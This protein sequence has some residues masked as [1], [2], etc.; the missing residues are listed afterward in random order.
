MAYIDSGN[1]DTTHHDVNIIGGDV[2]DAYRALCK[3]DLSS[4][5]TGAVVKTATLKNTLSSVDSTLDTELTLFRITQAWTDTAVTWNNAPEYEPTGIGSLSMSATEPTGLKSTTLSAFHINELHDGSFPDNGFLLL[6]SPEGGTVKTTTT[7]Y[8]R[9]YYIAGYEQIIVGYNE[10]YG[11]PIL[12]VVPIYDY[13]IR[14]ETTTISTSSTNKY[15]FSNAPY[16][17]LTYDTIA[18]P[19]PHYTISIKWY[20]DPSAGDLLRTDTICSENEQTTWGKRTIQLNS[21]A[22]AESYEIV[23]SATESSAIVYIDDISVVPLGYY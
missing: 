16:I 7:R 22:T 14:S 21:P 18:Y 17:D 10:T 13:Y 5:P 4:I 11:T 6:A 3:I 12:D 1:A 2:G 9:E 23:I 8:W 19:R 20:D 15:T